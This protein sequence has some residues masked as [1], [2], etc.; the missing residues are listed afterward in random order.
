MSAAGRFT[1]PGIDRVVLRS[2]RLTHSGGT[3]PDFHRLPCYARMGTQT[4]RRL[5]HGPGA[6]TNMCRIHRRA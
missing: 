6:G 1:F 3:A 2:D 4:E 5:Y